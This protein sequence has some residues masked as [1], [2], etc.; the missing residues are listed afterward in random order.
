M[1]VCRVPAGTV[2]TTRATM[3][4]IV[5]FRAPLRRG[6]TSSRKSGKTN[7]RP[8]W[9]GSVRDA[10]RGVTSS[11][12]KG[13]VVCP[14]QCPGGL[15]VR[16]V[17]VWELS[18]WVGLGEADGHAVSG[19]GGRRMSLVVAF[20]ES[21]RNTYLG[22]AAV[23]EGSVSRR[24]DQFV[25][26]QRATGQRRFH[27]RNESEARIRAFLKGCSDLGVVRLWVYEAPFPASQARRAII[28]ALAAD[29]VARRIGSLVIERGDPQ[30]DR[31]DRQVIASV[32]KTS[33]SVLFPYAHE[34]PGS[35]CG[36]EIA[37]VGAWAYGAG[38]E[39]RAR[40]G[41]LVEINRRLGFAEPGP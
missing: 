11:S 9:V 38:G 25:R 5:V 10:V 23:Y 3:R 22:V 12:R 21:L 41:Q 34:S 15:Y 18:G 26:G 7:S 39:W 2:G 20:D 24:V 30:R 8:P 36:L 32:L 1:K 29:S 40:V 4:P 6:L 37:D 13:V 27:A 33:D 14:R 31:H 35:H 17:G 19:A 16:S 28:A